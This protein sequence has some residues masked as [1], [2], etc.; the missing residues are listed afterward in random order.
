MKSKDLV[1][2]KGATHVRIKVGTKSSTVARNA[3][4]TLNGVEFDGTVFLQQMK[5]SRSNRVTLKPV[6]PVKTHVRD[7][8]REEKRLEVK[9]P[10]SPK[11][12]KLPRFTMENE[13]TP[14]NV[15]AVELP[16][17]SL[18][19]LEEQAAEISRKLWPGDAIAEATCRVLM[20]G[21]YQCPDGVAAVIKVRYPRSRVTNWIVKKA[22][23]ELL[24]HNLK[25]NVSVTAASV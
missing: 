3:I 11:I 16:V 13:L 5:N 23:P 17:P 18:I 10:K 8:R 14:A 20:T 21:A 6:G 12:D 15:P 4:D 24:K 2:P 1:F 9:K 7:M 25:V 22:V 19:P